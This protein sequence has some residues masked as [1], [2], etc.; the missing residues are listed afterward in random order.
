MLNESCIIY[1]RYAC[2]PGESAMEL[3]LC[4]QWAGH[5][6]CNSDFYIERQGYASVLLL[7]T[8]KGEGELF[9]KGQ[10][11]ALHKGSLAVIDCTEAHS[12]RPYKEGWEFLFVHFTGNNAQKMCRHIHSLS[13]AVFNKKDEYEPRISEIISLC[14]EKTAAYEATVSKELINLLYDTI[15]GI[16]KDES[17]RIQVICKYIV[18][19][20]E[21]KLS[22]THLAEMACMSRSRFSVLF[23]KTVGN[24]PHDYLLCTRINE[25]KKLLVTTELSVDEIAEKV[26]FG[27]VGTFI[28]AFS[29]K[30]RITPLKYRRNIAGASDF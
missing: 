9:Y 27:D 20:H 14:K 10:T 1:E 15:I 18:R 16:H 22:T 6:L 3:Y 7:Y 2:T 28:R 19:N 30:E 5:F 11:E 26:G 12:Y 4:P 24:S 29:R 13:G 8:V 25:A 17:N 23:K 21:R